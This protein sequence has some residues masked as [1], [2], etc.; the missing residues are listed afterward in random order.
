MSEEY[1]RQYGCPDVI[2]AHCVK[3][4]GRAAMLIA[5]H[6][7]IP[8]VITEHLPFMIYEEEFR[9][10]SLGQ[11]E[12]PLLREA[13]EKIKNSVKEAQDPVYSF[14]FDLDSKDGVFILETA[15][16]ALKGE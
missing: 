6:H 2:H 9:R 1:F 16:N 11:W 15:E 5:Q 8:Y 13:L 14:H 10:A 3:W 12:I 4:A 7:R